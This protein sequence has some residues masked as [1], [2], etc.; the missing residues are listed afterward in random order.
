MAILSRFVEPKVA[1]WVH[2]V[3]VLARIT[4]KYPQGACAGLTLLL[5]A[6]L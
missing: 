2:T 4:V 5:Q 6:E 1:N 3:K